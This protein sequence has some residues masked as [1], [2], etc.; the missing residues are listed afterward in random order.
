MS[1]EPESRTLRM[2]RR[3]DERLDRL[4]GDVSDMKHRQSIAE[5]RFGELEADEQSHCAVVVSRFDSLGH[6]ADWSERRLDLVD[7]LP[8]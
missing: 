2:L 1:D 5:R 4:N 8:A 6:R 7:H 3:I